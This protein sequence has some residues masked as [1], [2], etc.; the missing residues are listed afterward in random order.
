LLQPAS[1][2]EATTKIGI[3]YSR[4]QFPLVIGKRSGRTLPEWTLA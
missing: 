4:M 2:K 3:R 1:T